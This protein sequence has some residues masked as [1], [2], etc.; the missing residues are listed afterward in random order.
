MAKRTAKSK[1]FTDR[2]GVSVRHP[3]DVH[4]MI[5]TIA[6]WWGITATEVY[7][8]LVNDRASVLLKLAANE[9]AGQSKRTEWQDIVLSEFRIDFNTV[10][11]N[12]GKGDN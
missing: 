11:R 7:T 4:R 2:Y 3:A 10:P 6:G 1:D 9:M 5:S 8:T 12:P